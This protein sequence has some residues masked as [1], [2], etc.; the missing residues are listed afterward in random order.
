MPSSKLKNSAVT[1]SEKLE[2]IVKNSTEAVRHLFFFYL[3]WLIYVLVLVLSTTDKMLLLANEGL[4]L[5][6]VD[7]NVPLIGFYIVIPLFV[8]AIHIHLLINLESHQN[9][10][11]KWQQ[12]WGGSIAREKIHLLL[13]N[14]STL[15]GESS[16][17]YWINLASSIFYVY[18]GP[19]TLAIIFWRFADYQSG[20]ISIWHLL[21]LLI[22]ICFVI[23]VNQAFI[24]NAS[25]SSQ[26]QNGWIKIVAWGFITLV[27]TLKIIAV[28]WVDFTED[29]AFAS[30]SKLVDS[31]YE[32]FVKTPFCYITHWLH[33]D[34]L[35][36]FGITNNIFWKI[37]PHISIPPGEKLL[38]LEYKPS[39]L[40]TSAISKEDPELS[41]FN[42]RDVSIELSGRSLRMAFLGSAVLP[43]VGLT[44]ARLQ[45]ATLVLALLENSDLKYA[46]LQNA[47]LQLSHLEDAD[48]HGSY[49]QNADL[50][51]ASLI[52][53]RLT[54]A[55]LENAKLEDVKWAGAYLLGAKLNKADLEKALSQ[56]A[57]LEE[58]KEK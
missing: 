50:A 4:K 11:L 40:E 27:M 23:R 56:G 33:I 55:D 13:F 52:K 54:N 37:I 44:N 25:D 49:L 2:E 58:K 24:N 36:C 51:N 6:I 5:P 57:V 14:L 16:L 10:L 43:N 39:A 34:F 46:G 15:D 41:H 17:K 29:N 31:K 7:L 42:H 35:D 20:Y 1:K 19:L 45:G 30:Q 53:T 9:K 26:L 38:P 21:M 3:A 18:L 47:N 48:L 22:D 8:I 28:T 32:K 12:A